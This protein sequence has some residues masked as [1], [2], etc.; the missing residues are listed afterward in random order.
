MHLARNEK[1]AG[2]KYRFED[3]DS[4]TTRGGDSLLGT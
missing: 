1:S 2:D 3:L 4:V